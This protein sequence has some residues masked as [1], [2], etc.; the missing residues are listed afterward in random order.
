MTFAQEEEYGLASYYSDDFEGRSTA[1]G[2]TYNK[3][4]LTCATNASLTAP[5]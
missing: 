3:Q 4:E 5:C 2:D 1:Y